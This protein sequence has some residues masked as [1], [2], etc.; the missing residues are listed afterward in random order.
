[1]NTWKTILPILALIL[2][3]IFATYLSHIYRESLETLVTDRT[4]IGMTAY[5]LLMILA[6]VIAPLSTLPMMPI[7]VSL[8]G[9]FVTA[10]LSIVG[11]SIGATIAFY[12]SRVYGL[13]VVKKFVA[14][15]TIEK[16]NQKIPEKHNLLLSIILLRMIVPVD[17]LSYALGLFPK[18]SWR[19]YIIGSIIGVIPFSFI[20]AY[21]GG[22]SVTTQIIGLFILGPI[23]YYVW[24]RKKFTF[25]S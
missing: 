12:I 4:G 19:P 16:I 6:T 21:L 9:S 22:L 14:A 24:T 1:M 18:I 11:W 5:I 20:F 7:A 10:L 2:L 17:I 3:F 8:W 13:P 15:E 25:I 23:L